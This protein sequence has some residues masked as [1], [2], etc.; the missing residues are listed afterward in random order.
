MS[1]V[2]P[3]DFGLEAVVDGD[4]TPVVQLDADSV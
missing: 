3:G 2:V 4:A 1:L